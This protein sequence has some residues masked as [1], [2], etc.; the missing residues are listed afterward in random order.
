MTVDCWFLHVSERMYWY[1]FTFVISHILAQFA[2]KI[3]HLFLVSEKRNLI[4]KSAYLVRVISNKLIT[5]GRGRP[6]GGVQRVKKIVIKKERNSSDQGLE[7]RTFLPVCEWRARWTG[8][9]GVRC[10]WL[11]GAS[12]CGWFVGSSDRCFWFNCPP[13]TPPNPSLSLSLCKIIR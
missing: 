13:P 7:V 10:D 9:F 6:F 11:C 8:R 3:F 5:F 2:W 12:K 4:F 1:Y